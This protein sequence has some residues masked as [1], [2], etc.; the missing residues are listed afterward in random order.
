MVSKLVS[1]FCLASAALVSTAQAQSQSQT[2]PSCDS[3]CQAQFRGA[4]TG[5][6][7][8]YVNLDITTDSFY[9]TPANISSYAVGDLVKSQDLDRATISRLWTLPAGMSMSR[10]YYVTEDIDG[11]PLPATAFALIPYSNPLGPDKPFRTIAWAHGTAGG[12]RQCAPS[13]QKAFEFDWEGPLALAQRGFVV[14]APDYA[15][16][17]AEAP[18]GFMYEAGA[19][20]AHDVVHAIQAA[21]QTSSLGPLMS[22]EWVVIGHSEGGLTAWRTAERQGMPD[23]A[24]D[25]L[26]GAV[27]AAPATRPLSLI[28]E[29]FRRAN[30]K[31]VGDAPS[32]IFLQSLGRLFPDQI[33]PANYFGQVALDR[34][35]LAKGRCLISDLALFS[36]LTADELYKDKSWLTHPT[37]V[38]WQNRYNG[39]SGP[40]KLGTPL[41]VIQGEADELTYKEVAEKD[42]DDQCAALPDSAAEWSL[43]PGMGHDAS[44]QAGQAEIVAWVN[45]RF[46]GKPTAGKCVK[47]TQKTAT[48][49]YSQVNPV[50]AALSARGPLPPP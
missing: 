14:I 44:M 50:W 11:K 38:D 49:R 6:D 2:S 31:P 42:F 40:K 26:I 12:N 32:V 48:Q 9:Q 24:V 25:G 47:R 29:S 5:E 39:A 4:V 37:V 35:A 8:N 18:M 22:K 43:Y 15:G 17:G 41:L 27:A 23:K 13:N 34:L 33:K 21:R 30:G 36:T 16:M 28:P 1:L 3:V 19:L 10:I 20:H 7:A 45:D 46:D